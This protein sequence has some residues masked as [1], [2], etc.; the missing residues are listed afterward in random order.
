M[1]L[2]IGSLCA[3]MPFT[4][5]AAEFNGKELLQQIKTLQAQGKQLH[6]TYDLS[7]LNQLRQCANESNPLRVQAKGLPE[8]VLKLD[9]FALRVPLNQAAHLSFSCVYCSDS[10]IESCDKM[11]KYLERANKIINKS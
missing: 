3:F 5:N 4:I 6:S 9:D 7:D 1:R 2:L 10:A 11:D 8:Q